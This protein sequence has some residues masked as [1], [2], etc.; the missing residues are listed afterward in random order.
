MSKWVS[1]ASAVAL[2]AIALWSYGV[3][4][5]KGRAWPASLV[6]QSLTIAASYILFGEFVPQNRRHDPPQGASRERMVVHDPAAAMGEGFYA[7][8]GWDDDAGNYAVWLHDAAGALLHRWNVR[9]TSFHDAA[10]SNANNPQPLTIL[11]DG[12]IIV[13]FDAVDVMARLDPCGDPIWT[14]PGFFHHSFSRAEDG[15]VWTWYA[16][17]S[18]Y[19]QYQY[20]VKFD[21]ETGD[22]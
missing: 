15:G 2:G 10:T 17:R 16:E 12:S 18:A 22:V 3:A 19:E 20:M 6:D 8:Y 7:I 11:E 4:V 1:L 13:G 5:G 14:K 21:P 9:E